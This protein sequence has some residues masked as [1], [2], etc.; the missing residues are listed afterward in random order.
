MYGLY[1]G[2][3]IK[4]VTCSFIHSEFTVIGNFSSNSS[5]INQIQ[6][7]VVWGILSNMMSVPTDCPSR[8]ERRGYGGDAALSVDAALFNFDMLPFYD[9]WLVQWA[10]AQDASGNVPTVAPGSGGQGDPNWSTVLA[11]V[12]WALYQH[13][14]DV[15]VLQR[16][17]L[18]VRNWVEYMRTQYNQTGLVNLFGPIGDWVPPPPYGMTDIHL[19]NSFPFLHDVYILANMSVL[20]NRTSDT[21][22]YTALYSH[23]TQE[24]HKTWYS[25]AKKGYADGGQAANTLALALPGVVPDT[26]RPTVLQS[27]VADIVQKNQFTTGIVSTAQLFPLLSR[28]G[29]HDL[30]VQLIHKTD[31][32]SYAWQFMNPWE[33]AT[34]VWEIWNAPTTGPGMNSRNHHMYA[35]IGA[36]F[37]R[38]VAGVDL[39]AF[40]PILI[41]P[42]MTTQGDLMGPVH[43]EVQSV[44]GAVVVDWVRENGEGQGEQRVLMSV[45]VPA[46]TEARLTFDPLISQGRCIRLKEGGQMIAERSIG[47]LQ[48][49]GEVEGISELRESAVSPHSVEM[50]L[51]SGKYHFSAD[52]AVTS[53]FS[54]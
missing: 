50:K 48:G 18:T 17:Y 36:W 10:V 13:T 7:N 21:I 28:S 33:N 40:N 51:Q 30:A 41:H 39:N 8:D 2:S 49:V 22:T 27:L 29:H 16:H 25:D 1:D 11:T 42:R 44:A 14:G 34:T 52:W 9:S 15:S 6:H 32:P 20:L 43:V 47:G 38:Y 37:Y 31:Y 45:T 46:N 24:F 19:I 26:L 23:L 4:D 5:I 12:T 35:S 54:E 53:H 3:Q